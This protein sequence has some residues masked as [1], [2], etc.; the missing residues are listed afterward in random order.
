MHMLHEHQNTSLGVAEQEN[1]QLPCRDVSCSQPLRA[2]G[3]RCSAGS[4]GGR[5]GLGQPGGSHAQPGWGS[6]PQTV[7]AVT[8]DET[9][10]HHRR[11]E[12]HGVQ[13]APDV[14]LQ[15]TAAVGTNDADVQSRVLQPCPPMNTL[16]TAQVFMFCYGLPT[17]RCC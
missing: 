13:P 10:T 15:N 1:S 3:T 17:K 14:L 16:P 4:S 9:L 8:M 11:W 5:P 7:T 6:P 2:A 12:Q